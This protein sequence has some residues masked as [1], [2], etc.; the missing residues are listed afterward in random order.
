MKRHHGSILQEVLQRK[1]IDEQRILELT[2]SN[3]TWLKRLYATPTLNWNTINVIGRLISHDFAFD[4]PELAKQALEGHNA[5]IKL[6]NY[7]Q[8]VFSSIFL[9]ED[10]EMDQHI[11]KIT[12]KQ[13]V[14]DS[15]LK[16][17]NNGDLAINELLNM[18]INYPDKLPK[19]IFLD[20][21]M[22]V[23]G[24]AEFLDEF[25]RLNIDP[26]KK[27]KIHILTSSVFHSE[28]QK[29]KIHPLVNTFLRKPIEIS[30]LRSIL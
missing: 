2:N 24:G 3:R 4:F 11:F 16:T 10:S 12:L 26:Y 17:F 1:G 5:A 23:M 15:E 22:P 7:Q 18:S 27:I 6:Q 21:K 9:V 29:F 30:F 25:N 8:N 28:I 13:L 20:L 19:H 14:P